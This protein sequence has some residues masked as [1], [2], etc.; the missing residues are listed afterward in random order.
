VVAPATARDGPIPLARRISETSERKDQ[1]EMSLES[2]FLSEMELA[3]PLVIAP[4]KLI[5][6][7][8]TPGTDDT[9]WG[10]A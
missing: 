9:D 2:T 5:D 10:T 3:L 8:S 7:V 6:F 4:E 1:K